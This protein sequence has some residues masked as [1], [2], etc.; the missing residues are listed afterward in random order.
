MHV[1]DFDIM[2]YKYSLLSTIGTAG[3]NNIVTMIL[4]KDPGVFSMF[5]QADHDFISSWLNWTDTNL[6]NLRN[7]MPIATLPGPGLG[8]V[9]GTSAMHDDEGLLFRRRT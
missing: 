9:D 8:N 2:A 1:R 7:I 3:Q 6:D 5:S 4:A